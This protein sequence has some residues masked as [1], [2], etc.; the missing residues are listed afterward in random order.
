LG[1]GACLQGP[2]LFYVDSEGQR[3]RGDLFS[4]GSGS[5]YGTPTALKARARERVSEWMR[6]RVCVRTCVCVCVGGW[7][8][9]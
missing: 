4:V 7:V 8:C 1:G 3:L 2:G 5:T 6:A 9:V